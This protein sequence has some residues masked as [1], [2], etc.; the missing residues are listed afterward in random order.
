MIKISGKILAIFVLVL[1]F[2]NSQNLWA[3]DNFPFGE[4]QEFT[5]D[6]CSGFVD[7]NFDDPSLWQ[8]CCVKHDLTYW[9]GGTETARE[10]ADDQ[11]YQ[12][13]AEKGEPEVAALMYEAVRI[14]GTPNLPT[15]FRWGYGWPLER[16]YTKLSKAEKAQVK[17]LTP[18]D[19]SQVPIEG[20]F[21]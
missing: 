5:T 14:G 7:G 2:V 19:L 10:L 17:K 4:L 6:A 15:S 8:D 9:A 18:E 3:A 13:V 16:G 21:P 20:F 1:S 12:C 11:L